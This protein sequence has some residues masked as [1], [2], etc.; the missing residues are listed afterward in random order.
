VTATVVYAIVAVLVAVGWTAE[1]EPTDWLIGLM[2]AFA[3]GSG[4]P[5]WVVVFAIPTIKK[6]LR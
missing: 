3:V 5:L 1:Q 6:M 2:R 4:W